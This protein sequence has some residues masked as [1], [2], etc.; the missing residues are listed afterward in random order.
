MKITFDD[1]EDAIDQLRRSGRGMVAMRG[2]VEWL[3]R[4]GVGL[5]I[6]NQAAVLTLLQATWGPFTG[7]ARDAMH[8]AVDVIQEEEPNHAES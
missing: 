2:L 5:D 6:H 4:V 3:D 7:S 8:E 1:V